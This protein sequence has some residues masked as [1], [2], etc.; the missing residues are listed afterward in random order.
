MHS[1]FKKFEEYFEVLVLQ[2]LLPYKI[3]PLHHDSQLQTLF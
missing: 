3:L 1:L 2:I